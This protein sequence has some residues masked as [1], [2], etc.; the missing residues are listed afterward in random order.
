MGSGAQ[1]LGQGHTGKSRPVLRLL[2]VLRPRPDSRCSLCVTG[3]PAE[4]PGA[5]ERE[6]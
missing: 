5:R 6:R 4:G 2:S 1:K 3:Q